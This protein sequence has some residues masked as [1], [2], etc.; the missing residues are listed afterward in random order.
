MHSQL[1]KSSLFSHLL[2]IIVS[3][4]SCYCRFIIITKWIDFCIVKVTLKKSDVHKA[5]SCMFLLF[6][7]CN[8]EVV[9]NYIRLLNACFIGNSITMNNTLKLTRIA[10]R[11]YSLKPP[12]R[13]NWPRPQM[14]GPQTTMHPRFPG[15]ALYYLPLPFNKYK[16]VI[17]ILLFQVFG[18]SLPLLGVYKMLRTMHAKWFD[19]FMVGGRSN[20]NFFRNFLSHFHLFRDIFS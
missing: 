9:R 18:L 17:Y 3:W 13:K 8:F 6:F 5:N 7:F 4:L 16:L 20:L 11:H 10:F 19:M 12:G 15:W 1:S 14:L 2:L